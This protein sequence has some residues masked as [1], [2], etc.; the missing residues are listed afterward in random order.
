MRPRTVYELPAPVTGYELRTLDLSVV[1]PK[2]A[3][4]IVINPSVETN[5]TGYAVLGSAVL[6]RVATQ[7]RRGVYGLEVAVTAGG[8]GDG[9]SYGN[10]SL[11]AG[12]LY[13][14]AMD[15][16][17]AAGV[18]YLL[19][20]KTNVGAAI[21]GSPDYVFRATGRWQRIWMSY[22]ET[23]TTTRRVTVRKNGGSSARPFY[24]DG[25][26]CE[27]SELTTYFDG[28]LSGFVRGQ[29]AYYWLGQEHA[30]QSVRVLST[31]SG[32]VEM[33]LRDLG[34]YVTALLGLGLNGVSNITLPNAYA[35]GSQYQRTIQSEYT[36]DV[37]GSFMADSPLELMQQRR[38]LEAALRPNAGIIQ[39]PLLL[40]AQVTDDCGVAVGEP[41]AIECLYAGGL[42]GNRDN[43]YQEQA[44]LTFTVFLPFLGRLDGSAGSALVHEEALTTAYNAANINGDWQ[45]LSTGFDAQVMAMVVDEQRGR[46]YYGGVF[47][48]AGGVTV[49]KVCYWDIATQ[50]F[51]AM[52]GGVG[53]FNVEA[54]AIDAA[55]NVWVGGF[56]TTVGSGAAAAKSL[57]RW[58]AT[59]GTWTAFNIS[60]TTFGVI[61]DIELDDE[62]N[63]YVA[64]TFTNWDGNANS[65]H[66]VMYD[67]SAWSPL[68]TGIQLGAGTGVGALLWS[69]GYLYTGGDFATAGGV[70]NTL[71]MARW[72]GS[73]WLPLITGADGTVL[74]FAAMPDGTILIGGSFTAFGPLSVASI[75]Y[76]NGTSLFP[77]GDGT[78]NA[79]YEIHSLPDG[80]AL[81][82]GIFTSAGDLVTADRIAIWT[83]STF[84]PLDIDLP[85]TPIVYA[86]VSLRDD[87][88]LGFT[89]TGS[90]TIGGL[91][92]I[93]NPG[94]ADAYPKILITGPGRLDKLK[95]YT[96]GDLLAFNLTLLAGETAVL[97]LTPNNIRFYSNFRPNLLGTILPGSTLATFRLAPG[98]NALRFYI[99]G[100]D[101]NTIATLQYQPSYYSLDDTLYD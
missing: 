100:D 72:N 48:T 50:T 29:A 1:K 23:T 57:A 75:G 12:V 54:L 73:V 33:K 53:G 37:V 41:L 58:N 47:N 70:A 63:V 66:I 6:T 51:V 40:K 87:I 71:R 24:I 56:F 16:K 43:Y 55:G 42:Q 60:T 4:N 89:T 46:V 28:S 82:S 101:A 91:T 59:S 69:N 21:T 15:F 96:T 90:S 25:L 26:Q 61:A 30:S 18:S 52:D 94:S 45:Q 97:D 17:G 77:L 5:T 8:T 98:E 86:A 88:Y 13:F 67:G 92:T 76:W 68:G 7:Q 65:D 49:N 3:Q 38:A 19:G 62:G 35:G 2:A 99:T 9:V 83:G 78:N 34:F 84:L 79:V 81:L 36:F 10:I 20:V 80:T 39:Q 11:T 31:R 64:G 95:S 74:A 93:T 44:V 85:G 22:Q 32:G 14:V 27:T